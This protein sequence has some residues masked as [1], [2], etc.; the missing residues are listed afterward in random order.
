MSTFLQS[1]GGDESRLPGPPSDRIA[2]GT[3]WHR[4]RRRPEIGQPV[5]QLKRKELGDAARPRPRA[6][7]ARGSSTA[8]GAVTAAALVIRLRIRTNVAIRLTVAISG[9]R[10][11]IIHTVGLYRESAALRCSGFDSATLWKACIE[12]ERLHLAVYGNVRT[13]RSLDSL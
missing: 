8:A 11:W 1:S 10:P 4:Q 12:P 3:R 5:E 13:R 9:S 6:S 7:S 2:A